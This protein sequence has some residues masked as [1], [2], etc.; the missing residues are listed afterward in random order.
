MYNHIKFRNSNKN[1]N[2]NIFINDIKNKGE[3]KEKSL[4]TE[5]NKKNVFNL[6]RPSINSNKSNHISFIKNVNKTFKRTKTLSEPKY[7]GKSS[8]FYRKNKSKYQKK[9]QKKQ[10]KKPSIPIIVN[11]LLIAEEDKIFDE[12]KK[13]LCFKYEKKKIKK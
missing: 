13:Y 2:R 11:P 6:K 4:L 10:Q 9:P 1:I 8:I 5:R 12:M 3:D 7:Y